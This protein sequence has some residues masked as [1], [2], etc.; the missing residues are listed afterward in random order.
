MSKT[1]KSKPA[2]QTTTLAPAPQPAAQPSPAPPP[3]AI[4]DT[5]AL[6]QLAP[7][8][9]VSCPPWPNR[10]IAVVCPVCK[11]SHASPAAYITRLVRRG[12]ATAAELAWLREHLAASGI[13]VPA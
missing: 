8:A 5:T 11:E 12:S 7:L 1:K 10:R 3:E 2:K 9:D 4:G 6:A 13:Q